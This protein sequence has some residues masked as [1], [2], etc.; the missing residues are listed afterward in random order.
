MINRHLI[1][2]WKGNVHSQLTRQVSY[3]ILS[4]CIQNIKNGKLWIITFLGT[5]F[6]EHCCKEAFEE[7]GMP[8]S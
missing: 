8:M 4:G 1:D 6:T 7:N 3:T 5:A 2:G